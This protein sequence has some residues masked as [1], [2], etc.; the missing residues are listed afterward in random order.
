MLKTRA[1]EI[2]SVA[3]AGDWVSKAFDRVILTLI[4]VNVLAIVLESVE[5]IGKK[6][7][8]ELYWLE[9]VSVSIFSVEYLLRLWSCTVSPT[10]QGA[11]R[12]R[13][14]W[15]TSPFALID[16]LAVL[17]FFLPFL[18]V[19]LRFIRIFRVLRTLRLLKVG[20]YS[21]S[22]KLILGVLRDKKEELITSVVVMG[23]MIFVAACV[24]FHFEHQA[25]PEAFSSIPATLWWSVVTLTTIGYGDV[26]PV[27]AG[28]KV[29]ASVVAVI[30]IG[31]VGLPTAILASA[32]TEQLEKRKKPTKCPHCGKPISIDTDNQT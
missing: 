15:A 26:Y 18:G 20:K 5:G 1:W 24:M 22:L 21:S 16:L 23:F 14:K 2:A 4:L 31:M 13:L 19:D 8:V 10:Y 25:Q 17:P 6:F 12:G 32:F 28:G 11:I 27:T 3:K 7:A 29:V 30:A 9:V